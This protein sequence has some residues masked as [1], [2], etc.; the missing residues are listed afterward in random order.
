MNAL[1]SKYKLELSGLI[2]GAIA[3][4]CY[5]YFLGCASGN[6]PITSNPLHSTIY[7][8][9]VGSIAF[10]LLKKESSKNGKH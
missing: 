2:I 8:A 4:W 3:G 6:C 5:W 9:L 10:S 1:L 7:G